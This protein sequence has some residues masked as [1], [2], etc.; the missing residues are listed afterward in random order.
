MLYLLSTVKA[1]SLFPSVEGFRDG[2]ELESISRGG[3]S[4]CNT[5]N[6]Q[7]LRL[8]NIEHCIGSPVYILGGD[9]GN[10]NYTAK[11]ECPPTRHG[12]DGDILTWHVF[13]INARW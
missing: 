10:Q 5:Q 2:R 6:Y 13:R 1:V 3:R 11:V 9:G 12:N 7:A 8:V 4:N